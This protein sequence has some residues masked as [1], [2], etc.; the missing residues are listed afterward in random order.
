MNSLDFGYLST[1]STLKQVRIN[2]SPEKRYLNTSEEKLALDVSLEL[3]D[4]DFCMEKELGEKEL[5]LIA[6]LDAL[7]VSIIPNASVCGSIL[8]SSVL[9]GENLTSEEVF[10]RPKPLL[11]ET[12]QIHQKAWCKSCEISDF[13]AKSFCALM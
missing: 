5:N 9:I 12:S 13:N 3:D 11:L 2:S 8:K 4:Q 1:K 7:D 6:S 10:I